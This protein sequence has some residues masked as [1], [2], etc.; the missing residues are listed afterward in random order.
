MLDIFLSVT[1]VIFGFLVGSW[2]MVNM[3][4]EDIHI[5]KRKNPKKRK[6]SATFTDTGD[7]L[8]EGT[9]EYYTKE[10]AER[11][12]RENQK[13]QTESYNYAAGKEKK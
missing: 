13:A 9:M 12:I 7:D 1:F 5:R 3:I 10:E 8:T 11:L 4:K 2:F 6:V